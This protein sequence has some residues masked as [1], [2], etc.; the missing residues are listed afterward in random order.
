MYFAKEKQVWCELNVPL[1]SFTGK[2]ILVLDSVKPSAL[3]QQKHVLLFASASHLFEL[4][5]SSVAHS[6]EAGVM[7]PP[8]CVMALPM[9]AGVDLPPRRAPKSH[10][11]W[12]IY[13]H[14]KMHSN[15]T[16]L[17]PERPGWVKSKTQEIVS[18]WKQLCLYYSAKHEVLNRPW[19]EM[20]ACLK[21]C[22]Y[23]TRTRIV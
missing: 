15:L 21:A 23:R 13:R 1:L 8:P 4:R 20:T 11:H 10:P 18:M 17:L 14:H 22:A 19:V 3:A 9:T 12:A 5:H 7:H 16:W 6:K 2:V